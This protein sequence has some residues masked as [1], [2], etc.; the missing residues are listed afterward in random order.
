MRKIPKPPVQSFAR[1]PPLFGLTGDRY[2]HRVYGS[3]LFMFG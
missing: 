3:I 2:G 1:P